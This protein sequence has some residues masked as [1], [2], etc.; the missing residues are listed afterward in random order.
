[1]V[2]SDRAMSVKEAV[3]F[4]RATLG[5]DEVLPPSNVVR[6]AQNPTSVLHHLFEWDDVKAA[7]QWRL[8][9]ARRLIERP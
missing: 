7:R 5:R 3:W 6:A 2:P 9:Q 1:M 8:E 4:L